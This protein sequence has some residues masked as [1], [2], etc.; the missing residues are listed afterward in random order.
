MRYVKGKTS[1]IDARNSNSAC[2][3]SRNL[4]QCYKKRDSYVYL[5]REGFC[6]FECRARLVVLKVWLH[7]KVLQQTWQNK[8]KKKK[9]R[10]AKLLIKILFTAITRTY[11]LLTS[12][13]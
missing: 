7:K 1:L 8:K 12:G 10:Q 4:V 13:H 6:F 2:V 9:V 3:K 5:A 11:G